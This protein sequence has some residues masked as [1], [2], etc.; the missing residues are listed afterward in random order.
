MNQRRIVEEKVTSQMAPNEA[1][2]AIASLPSN[3]AVTSHPEGSQSLSGASQRKIAEL[4]HMVEEYDRH[5]KRVGV[6]P[7]LYKHQIRDVKQKIRDAGNSYKVTL[8]IESSPP[9]FFP[10]HRWEQYPDDPR[11]K[12]ASASDIIRNLKRFYQMQDDG[13]LDPDWLDR[14]VGDTVFVF[15]LGRSISSWYAKFLEWLADSIEWRRDSDDPEERKRARRAEQM[16]PQYEEHLAFLNMYLKQDNI[17]W[18]IIYIDNIVNSMHID[19]PMLE[20]LLGEAEKEYG[21]KVTDRPKEIIRELNDVIDWLYSRENRIDWESVKMVAKKNQRAIA[22][23]LPEYMEEYRSVEELEPKFIGGRPKPPQWV[24]FEGL[25]SSPWGDR[26]R[27]ESAVRDWKKEE[28]KYRRDKLKNLKTEVFK[29]LPNQIYTV[30]KDVPFRQGGKTQRRAAWYSPSKNIMYIN[31]YYLMDAVKDLSVSQLLFNMGHEC[32]HAFEQNSREAQD[33][34]KELREN[35]SDPQMQAY[36]EYEGRIK[37]Q[38]RPYDKSKY[39]RGHG[40][41]HYLDKPLREQIETGQL[42][43]SSFSE[44]MADSLGYLVSGQ[45]GIYPMLENAIFEKFAKELGAGTVPVL[46]EGN[47]MQGRFLE[48]PEGWV[49]EELEGVKWDREML[50]EPKAYGSI[51]ESANAFW[52]LIRY[53]KPL[54]GQFPGMGQLYGQRKIARQM[55]IKRVEDGVHML[56]DYVDLENAVFPSPW[57]RRIE[58]NAP[59]GVD[60]RKLVR[61]C[62]VV[63]DIYAV[64]KKGITPAWFDSGKPEGINLNQ[65]LVSA[66]NNGDDWQERYQ[67]TFDEA[68]FHELIHYIDYWVIGW[69]KMMESHEPEDSFFSEENKRR[70]Y[71]EAELN[72][73]AGEAYRL[74]HQGKSED[75]IVEDFVRH[76]SWFEGSSDNVKAEVRNWIFMLFKRLEDEELGAV[77]SQRA[78]AIG[79]IEEGESNV[80]S[81]RQIAHFETDEEALEQQEQMLH[82]LQK[83]R[84]FREIADEMG[85]SEDEVEELIDWTRNRYRRAASQRSIA[86]QSYQPEYLYPIAEDSSKVKPNISKE[87]IRHYE[88]LE[89]LRKKQMK[90]ASP[91][92]GPYKAPYQIEQRYMDT[93]EGRY[94]V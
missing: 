29:R 70:H 13:K 85:I 65:M 69:E 92:E 54:G 37:K 81:Q 20:H 6:Y 57:F 72:A 28:S 59:S 7:F 38:L 14:H 76:H 53:E 51:Y 48:T 66:C 86:W 19:L 31:N 88:M 26:A 2:R 71:L 16:L 15:D 56:S 89:M 18:V 43:K 60:V 11:R 21:D 30:I 90:P 46:V 34:A 68:L 62:K 41:I 4:Y 44:M 84:T 64:N 23:A 82:L 67:E 93:Q 74:F 78:L 17:N 32:W 58:K 61:N 91:G 50:G 25:M 80:A 10:G 1:Q 22:E 87:D 35:Q 8:S 33:F 79:V 24:E 36:E 39:Y 77:A 3:P 94:T 40:Y 73:Y 12:S 47:E 83:M 55:W 49:C 27:Y 42:T 63:V 52:N 75:E 5:G 9:A 45:K